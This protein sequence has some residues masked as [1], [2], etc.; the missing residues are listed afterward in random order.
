MM[1]Q[2]DFDHNDQTDEE[3]SDDQSMM[4]SNELKHEYHISREQI[5]MIEDMK[6]VMIEQTNQ[7][8]NVVSL[9]HSNDSSILL[10]NRRFLSTFGNRFIHTF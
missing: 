3:K 6:N 1:N 5:E 2:Y 10:G 8:K 7:K 9:N 4:N